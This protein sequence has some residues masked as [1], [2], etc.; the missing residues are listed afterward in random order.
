VKKRKITSKKKKLH[1]SQQL[2]SFFQG[3][4][5]LLFVNCESIK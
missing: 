4:D 3:T 1:D 5:M 2:A